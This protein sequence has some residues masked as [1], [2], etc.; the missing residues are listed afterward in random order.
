MYPRIVFFL[1]HWSSTRER[2]KRKM[3][4]EKISGADLQKDSEK[5]E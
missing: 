5:L 3:K 1:G 2:G 4:E